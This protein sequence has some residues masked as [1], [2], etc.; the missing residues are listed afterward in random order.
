[1]LT[2][3]TKQPTVPLTMKSK[4]Q[5]KIVTLNVLVQIGETGVP[6]Y[7][8]SVP[9]HQKVGYFAKKR[10]LK[11][12]CGKTFCPSLI[13]ALTQDSVLETISPVKGVIK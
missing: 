5:T 12:V 10:F 11:G 13:Y 9:Q 3:L 2:Q 4:K 7:T 1:M 8:V 6:Y